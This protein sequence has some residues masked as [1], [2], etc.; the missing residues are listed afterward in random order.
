MDKFQVIVTV[1]PSTRSGAVLKEMVKLGVGLFRV[2]GAHASREN[3]LDIKGKIKKLNPQAKIILDLPGNKIRTKNLERSIELKRGR[4]FI[5][6]SSMVN[7]DAFFRNIRRGDMITAHDSLL[8][9]EVVKSNESSAV[10]LSHSNG[11]L[12]NGKGLHKE[13]LTDKIEFLTDQDKRLIEIARDLKL[14]CISLSYV[15]GIK[16]VREAKDFISGNHYK[17]EIFIKIETKKVLDR[18]QDIIKEGETFILDRGDMSSEVGIGHIADIQNVVIKNAKVRG[19][20]IFLAT[21]F[22]KNM[23][24]HPVPLIAEVNDIHNAIAKGVSGIQLSEETAVGR[25]P[26]ECVKFVMRLCERSFNGRYHAK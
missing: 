20:R 4:K 8:S 21:Q 26:V 18:I 1:G 23:I 15:R 14:D 13:G 17:P 6:S 12:A 22:L 7:D 11:I 9:F 24:H 25:Y 19:R 2:N 16:D 3:I 5:L 10:F